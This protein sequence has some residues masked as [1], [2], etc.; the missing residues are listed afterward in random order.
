MRDRLERQL[1]SIRAR[2]RRL[3]DEAAL[4]RAMG[5]DALAE[6]I[7]HEQ[8]KAELEA[9]YLENILRSAA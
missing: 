7:E 8:K 4:H 3:E 1:D 5:R 9:G 6:R 2:I